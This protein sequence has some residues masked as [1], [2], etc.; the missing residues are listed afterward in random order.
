M[1]GLELV[2]QHKHYAQISLANSLCL[3]TEQV[4]IVPVI[5]HKKAIIGKL[6]QGIISEFSSQIQIFS[7]NYLI[8]KR[9]LNEEGRKK[10]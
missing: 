3:G 4:V 7:P 1:E 5:P 10:S 8:V 9:K 2:C 6:G